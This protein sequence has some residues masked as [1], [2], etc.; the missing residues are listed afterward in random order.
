[1]GLRSGP[2]LQGVS[3]EINSFLWEAD[4]LRTD[5]LQLGTTGGFNLITF[6]RSWADRLGYSYSVLVVEPTE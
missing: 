2:Q 3:A 4:N 1:M 5:A 6:S